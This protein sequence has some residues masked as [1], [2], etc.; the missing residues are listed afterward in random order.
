LAQ[1]DH[2]RLAQRGGPFPDA[3]LDALDNPIF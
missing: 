3:A 2:F 1:L